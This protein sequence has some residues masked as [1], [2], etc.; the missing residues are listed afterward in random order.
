M[1]E[2]YELRTFSTGQDE[3]I[4]QVVER[5][6]A[7]DSDRRACER[8]VERLKPGNVNAADDRRIRDCFSMDASGIVPPPLPPF[9]LILSAAGSLPP[10]PTKAQLLYMA[11][12]DGVADRPAGGARDAVDR[13]RAL[14]PFLVGDTRRRVVGWLDSTSV[15]LIEGRPDDAVARVRRGVG[16]AA[17]AAGGRARGGA[18][19]AP[20]ATAGLS[21]EPATQAQGLIADFLAARDFERAVEVTNLLPPSTDCVMVD[22]GFTGI[23]EL[24]LP[25]QNSKTVA[26]YVS[27]L[28]AS[29]SLARLCPN[30]LDDELA[31]DMWLKAGAES[32]ALEAASRSGK[33]LVLLKARLSIVERRMDLG[34]QAGARSMLQT[35]TAAAI[36]SGSGNEPDRAATIRER[37]RLIHLLARIGD[38]DAAER[39]ASTY[40]GPGWR[41]FAYSVIFAT[42]HRGQAGPNWGGP[43]LDLQEVSAEH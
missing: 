13:L 23:V 40:P 20:P 17:A 19:R 41:G 18:A 35:A 10:G 24:V 42:T 37:L 9:R 31:A 7:Q 21:S 25:T 14:I 43:F 38:V 27:R 8:F 15:D 39:L 26:A 16:R 30:G 34:D 36:A 29:G 12:W 11:T 6:D 33:P 32:R 5:H 3:L 4:H 1:S 22:D 2:D 28:Q